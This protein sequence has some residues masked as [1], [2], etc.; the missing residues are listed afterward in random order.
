MEV[1]L[2]QT[3]AGLGN[4]G[5][6][7]KVKAGYARNYLIPRGLALPATTGLR[8]QA[9][10]LQDAAERR[11][12]R[13]MKSAR[14]LADRISAITLTF[15]ARAGE[16]GRLYGSITA[17]TIAEALSAKLGQEIDRRRL[18]LEHSLRD[19]GEHDLLLH[20]TQGVDAT[21]KVVVTAEGELERDALSA[22]ELEKAAEAQGVAL[23][24]EA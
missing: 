20:L 12:L 3:I 19:L 2:K 5:E 23:E 4:A 17:A 18:R 16:S 10:Q 15:Q 9:Q 22:A 21:F 6:I 8:N 14:D 1:L 7:H 13:E 24:D 11:R